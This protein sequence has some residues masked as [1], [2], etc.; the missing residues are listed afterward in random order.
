MAA[1][2][3][4]LA[5][6]LSVWKALFLRESVARLFSARAA[7]FWLLAEPAL[8]VAYLVFLYSV[9]RV[10][11]IGGI[12]S[13]VW[14]LTGLLAFFMFRRT[15]TQVMN[16]VGSNKAL[17]TYRQVKPVDTALVRGAVEGFL[18]VV[19]LVIELS[20]FA[21]LGHRV[22]PDDP[23]QVLE[24]FFS[25][26]L[27]A[28]GFGLTTSVIAE[29][30]PEAGRVIKLAMMPLYLISGVMFSIAVVPP[31]YREWLMLNPIAHGLEV[32][33]AGFA[34]HYHTIPEVSLRYLQACALTSVFFGLALHRRF[35]VR[36]VT[37]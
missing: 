36:L 14:I 37:Q 26:W 19:I 4:H 5:V 16:A 9:I 17:F 33:R 3:S 30:V 22:L 25:L 32:V 11:T 18:M 1:A 2:R 23:M 12:D 35:A 10:R 34:S 24:A 27:L 20:G 29:L 6:T 7:W 8:H 21:L 28:I 13:A 15:G 31:P